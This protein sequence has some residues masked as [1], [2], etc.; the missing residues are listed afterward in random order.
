[1][2]GMTKTTDTETEME[3]ETSNDT[4]SNTLAMIM[5]VLNMDGP[6]P[7]AI[8]STFEACVNLYANILEKA[9]DEIGLLRDE[10]LSLRDEIT[11]LRC[12]RQDEGDQS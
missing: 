4:G 8:V 10:I 3:T 7:R 11:E 12:A 1:M 6:R 2:T 5:D 9:A